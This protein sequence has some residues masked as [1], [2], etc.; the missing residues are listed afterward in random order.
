MFDNIIHHCFAD[1]GEITIRNKFASRETYGPILTKK[2]IIILFKSKIFYT[3]YINVYGTTG[4]SL[5]TK[6]K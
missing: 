4:V 6:C 3:L 5:Q 1:T 2:V